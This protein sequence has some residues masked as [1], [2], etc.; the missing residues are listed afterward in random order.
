MIGIS[1]VDCI[2]M[3]SYVEL[4]LN[5]ICSVVDDYHQCKMQVNSNVLPVDSI[6]DISRE[7]FLYVLQRLSAVLDLN[8]RGKDFVC[9]GGV[10]SKSIRLT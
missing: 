2:Q 3:F 1:V 6:P 9:R 5:I 4:L 10:S 8:K 7:R